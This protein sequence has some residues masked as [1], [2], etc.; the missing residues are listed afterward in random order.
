MKGTNLGEFQELV[1]LTIGVLYPEAYGVSIKDEIR[2]KTGRKVTLSTVH[3]A[4]NRLEK[5]GLVSSEFGEATSIRGGKRKRYF[6]IT[7]SGVKALEETREQREELWNAI[8]QQA[9][10]VK[11]T[12]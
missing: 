2:K 10:Q 4:L 3:G 8:P 12:T 11:L 1:L 9:L 6:T 5:K 7:S